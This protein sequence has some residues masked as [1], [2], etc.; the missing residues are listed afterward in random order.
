MTVTGGHLQFTVEGN[1]CLI[2]VEK[3]RFLLGVE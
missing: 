3:I 2:R 1:Q